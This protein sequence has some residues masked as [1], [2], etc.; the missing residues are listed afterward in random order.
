MCL[1]FCA[2]PCH[3]MLYEF[4]AVIVFS[5]VFKLRRFSLCN[6]VHPSLVSLS[7]ENLWVGTLSSNTLNLHVHV[8]YSLMLKCYVP[9]LHG[10]MSG[11]ASL[12]PGI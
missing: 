11:S 6:F 10:E 4:I 8:C 5:E 1:I 12:V 2:C 9:H 7:C 3:L